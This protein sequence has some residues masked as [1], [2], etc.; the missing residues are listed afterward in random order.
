MSNL[1]ERFNETANSEEVKGAIQEASDRA[2]SFTPIPSGRYKVRLEELFPTINPNNGLPTLKGRMRMVVGNR[3]IFY[4]QQLKNIDSPQ[5]TAMNIANAV[6]FVSGAIG[7]DVEFVNMGQFAELITSL[8]L[9]NANGEYTLLKDE[10]RSKEFE[11]NLWYGKNDTE[12][13]YPK[14]S[15]SI[16]ASEMEQKIV[17]SEDGFM[18]IPDGIEEDLPFN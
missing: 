16:S 8:N 15:I 7:K 14:V 12:M 2:K 18:S 13:K 10:F 11:V 6:T 3:V 5:Y 9:Q 17:T 1:W 4:N